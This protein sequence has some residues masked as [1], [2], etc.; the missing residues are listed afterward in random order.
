[1][2]FWKRLKSV[3]ARGVSRQDATRLVIDAR[4]EALALEAVQAK[5]NYTF[6]D[7]YLL[8]QALV[9]RSQTHI[10][11]GGRLE[12]NE[13]LEFLGDSVLGLV[14]NAYLYRHYPLLEEG[15][16]TKMKSKLVCGESLS[17]VASR[18]KLGEHIQMSRGEAATGGRK[19][20]SILAD[21]VEAI[22][23][24]VYLDG[25]LKATAEVIDLWLLEDA[26]AFLTE[27]TLVNDK[28]RLQEMIQARH[29]SPPAYRLVDA[30]G[31]DHARTFMVEVLFGAI[32]LGR[33]AGPSKKRAEQAAATAAMRRLG[34][35]PGL[36]DNP[37]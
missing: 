24:A 36:L 4:A 20:A 5:L 19:R 35:Q 14:V 21:A 15:D 26:D 6:T 8:R 13:R 7:P 31:P 34:T 22:I 28:S 16:L 18:L 32:V 27:R 37:D 17:R 30:S 25:G 2:G 33:G 3:V 1:M 12:S 10:L 23:G 11:G 29:K 9:H